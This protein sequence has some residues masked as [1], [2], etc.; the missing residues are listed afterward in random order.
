MRIEDEQN[1]EIEDNLAKQVKNLP[2]RAGVYFM[3][4]SAGE[5]LYVGKAKNLRSR[6]RSYFK[7]HDDRP[8]VQFLIKKVAKIETIVV[9]TENQAFIIERDLI[10]K[11]KPRYNIRLKDNKEYLSVRLDKDVDWPRVELVRQVQN[12]GAQYFG[13]YS[14]S[15]ELKRLLDL[16]KKVVPLRTC[17]DTVFYNRQR[18]CLEYQIKRC[19]APCCLPV[20]RSQYGAWIKQAIAILEGKSEGIV[21]QLEKE[22]ERASVE[23]RFEDAVIYR[24][25]LS[26][27]KSARDNSAY[28]SNRT[29]SQDIYAIHR[30]Q[31]LAAI[32]ILRVRNGRVKESC[33][34]AFDHLIAE[35]NELIET[36]LL[37]FYESGHG[38]VDEVVLPF[39]LPN[40]EGLKATLNKICGDSPEII[41]PQRGTK[42][43]LLQLAKLNAQQ[44]FVSEFEE[45][46]RSFNTASELARLLK[47][48][49]IPRRI[50]CID[51]S[52]LQGSD[53]VGGLVVFVD[54]KP[55][56]DLYR[57]YTISFQD[58]PN[59]FAAIHEVV[60]RRLER[61]KQDQDLPDLLIIDGGPIQLAKALEARDALEI[62]LEIV[63]IA[64]IKEIKKQVRFGSGPLIKKPERFYLEGTTLPIELEAANPVT[65]LVQRIRDEVHRFVITFH[66]QKRAKRA[67]TSSLDGI[68]GIGPDKRTRLLNAYGSIEA[69]KLASAQDIA[70]AGR[71]PLPLA[72]KVLRR[73][74][75]D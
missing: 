9:D 12:D 25:R 72:Q 49:Q 65:H 29:D 4:D 18:P 54:G 22:M 40:L 15:Y 48:K 24:D 13:P 60:S 75:G 7:G 11:F 61:A 28:Y 2:I 46:S 56:K 67:I 32:S 51:I 5:V 70:K 26:A 57:R 66:R 10:S 17:S 31:D 27:L 59:D 69:I 16:I 3:R 14:F 63:S 64:K 36:C 62:E 47:L 6:V 30:Q 55:E 35:D 39:E 43:R 20:E 53:I 71:M 73:L 1:T 58:K 42:Y 33:N 68:L 45:E 38:L 37:Q 41:V 34:Y 50:E 52:N 8:Q 21:L 74:L 23:M 19:A 44:H